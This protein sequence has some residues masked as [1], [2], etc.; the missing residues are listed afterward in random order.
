MSRVEGR[1][2]ICSFLEGMGS[3]LG[4]EEGDELGGVDGVGFLLVLLAV[5]RER[6][7]VGVW[8]AMLCNV[9][10][11]TAVSRDGSNLEIGLRRSPGDVHREALGW[12]H[13]SL[14]TCEGSRLFDITIIL[15]SDFPIPPIKTTPAIQRLICDIG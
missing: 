6:I 14:F 11:P 12:L 10:G 2:E 3:G 8:K 5:G 9:R 4:D 13:T 1:R 7:F 15:P